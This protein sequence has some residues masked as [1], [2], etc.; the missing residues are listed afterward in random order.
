MAYGVVET[1]KVS[2]R[3]F[4]FYNASTNI[5]NG[6][7]VKKGAPKQTTVGSTTVDEREIYTVAVPTAKDRVFLV[8]N[9]AWSYDD[10]RVVNQNEDNF[11][12]VAGV[13][14]RGYAL[15]KDDKFGVSDYTITPVS[16]ETAI[17]VG[18]YI[19]ID[20][21]T[22]KLKDLG[23]TAP[24]FTAKAFVGIVR[25]V[26]SY[27]VELLVGAGL[28]DGL[29]GNVGKKVVIEVLQNEDIVSE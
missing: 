18:D 16:S 3:C 8:A 21:T 29:I 14:F 27:G 22:M 17:A 9:P 2:G 1:T 13:P 23:T 12:N 19:G 6:W 24:D 25:E 28:P 7:V 4:S 26:E 5:E 11:I 20:G 15:N 10:S